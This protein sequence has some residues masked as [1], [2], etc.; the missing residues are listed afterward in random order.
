MLSGLVIISSEG[1]KCCTFSKRRS[2]LPEHSE[3]LIRAQSEDVHNIYNYV[4]SHGQLLQGE[5][6]PPFSRVKNRE[7][8][9]PQFRKLSY[10]KNP[11]IF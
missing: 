2:D 6:K 3:Y 10:P 8:K 7:I 4:K 1:Q 9:K 5:I 11:E